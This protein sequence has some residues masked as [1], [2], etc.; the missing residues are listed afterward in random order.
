MFDTDLNIL[1]PIL[2]EC[3]VIKSDL[4]LEIIQFANDISSEAHVEVDYISLTAFISMTYYL[5]V[6]AFIFCDAQFYLFF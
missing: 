3:R 4:E 5:L 1:H 6:F 2:T